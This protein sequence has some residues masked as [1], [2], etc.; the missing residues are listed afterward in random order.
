MSLRTVKILFGGALYTTSVVL[1]DSDGVY[2]KVFG[3]QPLD[4]GNNWYNVDS[5]AARD[6][7]TSG[8]G[9]THTG[10]M[11]AL[12]G[13]TGHNV[14]GKT[15]KYNLEMADGEYSVQMYCGANHSNTPPPTFVTIYDS[16]DALLESPLAQVQSNGTGFDASYHAFTLGAVGYDWTHGDQISG[17]LSFVQ[18]SDATGAGSSLY[19]KNDNGTTKFWL[20]S[21]IETFGSFN[22]CTAAQ[23]SIQ[24]APIGAVYAGDGSAMIATSTGKIYQVGVNASSARGDVTLRYTEDSSPITKLNYNTVA[25][26][27]LYGREDGVVCTLN[28]TTWASADV[29][30]LSNEYAAGTFAVDMAAGDDGNVIVSRN[31]DY[32]FNVTIAS[33]DWQTVYKAGQLNLPISATEVNYFANQD[34]W[35]AS[36]GVTTISTTD[37]N[38]WL[39]Q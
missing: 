14:T 9:L 12:D 21:D 37:I 31:A 19:L 35:Y 5:R 8:A 33:L 27:I 29:L 15:F 32:T 34:K 24:G 7:P 4:Y 26:S 22:A 2:F 13:G 20:T 10:E 23:T 30:N 18:G 28:T 17:I 11:T 36:D 16:N 6:F 25:S 3:P 1:K 39:A 38:T